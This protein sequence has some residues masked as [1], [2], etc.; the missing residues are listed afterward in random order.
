MSRDF[1]LLR[2][3]SILVPIR[4]RPIALEFFGPWSEVLNIMRGRGAGSERTTCVS[5]AS[6]FPSILI[7]NR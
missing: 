6:E 2:S 7:P 4:L 5:G 1:P 3:E